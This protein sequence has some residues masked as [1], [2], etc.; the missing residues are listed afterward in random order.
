VPQNAGTIS[1]EVKE[2]EIGQRKRKNK[3][4]KENVVPGVFRIQS[5]EGDTR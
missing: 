2:D 1:Q 3:G 4:S 5:E